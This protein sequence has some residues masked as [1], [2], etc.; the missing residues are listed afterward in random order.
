MALFAAALPLVWVTSAF[1]APDQVLADFEQP[2]YAGWTTTGTAFGSGPVDRPLPNQKPVTGFQ[3]RG[4][5]SSYHGTDIS[6]GTLTSPP[7][8]IANKFI[9]FLIGGGG[10]SGKTCINLIV[11]DKIV[12]SATGANDE[13]LTWYTWSTEK[14]IGQKARLQIVDQES[15]SWGHINIDQITQTDA[16]PVPPIM[17][18]PLYQETYRPLFHFTSQK[19]WLN[20]PNGCV[21]Y[22]GEY[23]LFFQHNPNGRGW[24]NMTWGHAV[25]PD[26][27]HWTQLPNALTPDKMGTMFSGSAV[28]DWKNTSGFG[29]GDRPPLVA[30]YTAAGGSSAASK[31]Q[32]FTQC[33]AFSNDRGRTWTKFAGNPVIDNIVGGNRDPKLVWHEPTKRWI[34]ALFL[35]HDL[36][37]GVDR[38]QYALFASPDMKKWT[39]LQQFAVPGCSECPDFFPMHVDGDAA[40]LKWVFTAANGRYLVGDFDGTTFTPDGDVQQVDFGNSD[41][42]VQSFS[43]TPDGRRIQIGWMRRARFPHMP[44][45]QQMS[46][47]AELTLRS[48]PAGPRLFKQPI[49]EIATLHAEPLVLN[50]IDLK[51]GDNPLEKLHGD[52]FHLQAE[53]E[54]GDAKTF[55]FILRGQRVQYDVSEKQLDALGTAALEPVGGRIKLD[56]LLDRTTIETFAN[57]GKVA[58]SSWYLAPLQEQQIAVFA[59]GG[60]AKIVSLRVFPIK[61]SWPANAE[62]MDK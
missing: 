41:Y 14:L 50:N 56:V 31:G 29:T 12:E 22:D 57:D 46:F 58:M 35:N 24:G 32:K 45:N 6:Q 30:M 1:A 8:T 54:P 18:S 13:K 39:R 49:G 36:S 26:L 62:V 55:G 5:A 33:L 20:D 43:D 51:P 9:S 52:A 23:H 42:A 27:V 15:G 53:F 28:V 44:F 3:G 11:D 10:H 4:Y 34:A 59:E 47:P 38:G 16:P 40:K 25:S 7:F 37:T 17:T 48:T 61:S 19:N 2:G 60:T 21:F